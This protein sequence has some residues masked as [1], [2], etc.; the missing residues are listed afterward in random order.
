MA[1]L[2][3]FNGNVKIGTATVA[4]MDSW[5]LSPT[6]NIYDITSFNDAW[7][8]KLGGLKDWT[9]KASGKYDLT[10]TNGQNA[11]W[12]AFINGTTVSLEL[13][14]D[15]THKFTGTAFVKSP[16]IKVGVDAAETIEFD[17]EGSGAIT[18]A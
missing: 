12:T 10:D 8:T 15:G 6:A 1:A 9:A 5:E 3:G 2:V 14:V 4:L 16:P 18:Y 7:K 13:D 17:F 11:I